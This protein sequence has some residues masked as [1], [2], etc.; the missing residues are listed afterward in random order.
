MAEAL[1][2]NFKSRLQSGKLLTSIMVTLG[3][4]EICELL[5]GAG[6]DWLFI[7]SEHSPLTPAHIQSMLQ[8]AGSG[9]PCLVRLIASEE[10]YI[11]QAL[12]TGAAGIIAPMVN[13]AEKAEEVVRC[14]KYAPQ[15]SRGVG[16]SRAHQYGL[17]FQEY[18][19]NANEQTTVVI[20]AEHITAV[21]NIEEIV[22]VA[23]I[24][25]VFVG[26]NDLAASLNLIGQVDH[27]KVIA[28]IERITA[29]CHAANMPLGIF[30]A[31]P[32]AVHPYIARGYTLI[33]V[34]TDTLLL[35]QSAARLL[36]QLKR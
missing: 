14:A 9:T 6:F 16:I 2:H 24:D 1:T 13:S 23:G 26:P 5:A 31:T 18:L 20:Q 8:G 11:K 12:D 21:E 28:A 27:P 35:T 25:A 32:S 4:A 3:S 34:A 7:D 15:G 17:S 22:Q 29:V 33:T 19:A 10:V 30:G 36:D